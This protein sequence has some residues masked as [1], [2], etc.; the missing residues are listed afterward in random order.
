MNTNASE[1]LSSNT[2]SKQ[3]SSVQPA[4]PSVVSSWQQTLGNGLLGDTPVTTDL[5]DNPAPS[6]AM[7]SD[8]ARSRFFEDLFDQ[9]EH[10][11][12]GDSSDAMPNML[13]DNTIM[14]PNGMAMGPV[15]LSSQNDQVA[16][17]NGGFDSTNDL[18]KLSGQ[19]LNEHMEA[20][21]E[22]PGAD[23]VSA[24]QDSQERAATSTVQQSAST[25]AQ[26][27]ESVA[28]LVEK[29]VSGLLVQEPDGLG[30]QKVMLQL[31]SALFPNTELLL[32]QTGGVWRLNA[33]TKNTDV[34]DRLQAAQAKLK[35]R[36]SESA[37]GEIELT[38][39]GRDANEERTLK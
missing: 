10:E 9:N 27:A 18:L 15:I 3:S 12:S 39:N 2:P 34:A 37:L 32:S 35:G 23:L 30:E 6:M 22:A 5:L 33:N 16:A 38:I 4:P 17:G 26:S 19:D 7:D 1:V 13:M 11:N 25:Y 24:W 29:Y 21:V 36:F 14:Q 28:N 20:P 8:L 31:N